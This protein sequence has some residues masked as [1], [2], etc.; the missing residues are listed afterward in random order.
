MRQGIVN[1][2]VVLDPSREEEQRGDGKLALAYMPS[3]GRVTYMLQAG[4]IHHT[5]LQEAVDLCTDA[6]TGVMR[7]LLTASL[8]KALS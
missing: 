3:M 5:Q 1:G 4:Q 6:C 8:V 7:T 2:S